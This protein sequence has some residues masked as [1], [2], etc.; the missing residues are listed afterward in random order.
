MKRKSS[1]KYK[2]L[3]AEFESLNSEQKSQCLGELIN[4]L[5]CETSLGEKYWYGRF[6][7]CIQSSN[8]IDACSINMEQDNK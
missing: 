3:T 6:F 8:N 2:E 1:H 5:S 7:S 4:C